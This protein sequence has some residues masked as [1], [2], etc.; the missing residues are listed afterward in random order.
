M[1]TKA[2]VDF[3]HDWLW[4]RLPVLMTRETHF[5]EVR[6]GGLSVLF[7][8]LADRVAAQT[9][10]FLTIETARPP[11][12]CVAKHNIAR[13]R[14]LRKCGLP[15]HGEGGARTSSQPESNGSPDLVTWSGAWSCISPRDG[16]REY[17]AEIH[18]SFVRLGWVEA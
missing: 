18:P 12:A 3:P 15:V 5:R 9:A 2:K 11:Y 4:R 1:V 6:E 7:E 10:D 8:H 13:A 16:Q 14:V 17:T